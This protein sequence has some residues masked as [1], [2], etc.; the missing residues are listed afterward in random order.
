MP[1]RVGIRTLKN[2]NVRLWNGIN[3]SLKNLARRALVHVNLSQV[4]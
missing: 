3:G 2:I 4:L 1:R